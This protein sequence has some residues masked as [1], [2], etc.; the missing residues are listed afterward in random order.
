MKK[1]CNHIV[2]FN[3]LVVFD[4]ESH[5][6]FL[7]SYDLGEISHDGMRRVCSICGESL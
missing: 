5:A 4:E 2:R 1:T 6:L 7:S 3:L